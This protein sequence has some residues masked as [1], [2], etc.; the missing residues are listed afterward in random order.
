MWVTLQQARARICLCQDAPGACREAR[1]AAVGESASATQSPGSKASPAFSGCDT[2]LG[3]SLL[4]S[5]SSVRPAGSTDQGSECRVFSPA[6][7]SWHERKMVAGS[8]SWS[9]PESAATRCDSSHI[10]EH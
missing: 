4:S 6:D 1:Q 5:C 2:L 10:S 8:P 9:A 3:E 7:A